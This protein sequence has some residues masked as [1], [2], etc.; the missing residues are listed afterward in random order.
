MRANRRPATADNPLLG[1]ERMASELIAGGLDAWG[2]AR[3]ALTEEIFLGV[4]GAPWLQAMVGLSSDDAT[5]KRGVERDLARE[6]AELALAAHLAQRVE[7]GGLVGAAVRALLYV[8]LPDSIA[9]ERGFA[10]LREIASELPAAKRLGLA[11]FKELVREQFLILRLDEERAIALPN[12]PPPRDNGPRPG[13]GHRRG[14]WGRR[15]GGRGRPGR[16]AAT[17]SSH[18]AR[19][20]SSSPRCRSS[21]RKTHAPARM[22]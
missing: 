19:S 9:D 11:R 21:C 17:R 1:Y 20:S 18:P 22:R 10:A 16:A 4:Y 8:R 2:K 7:A 3:D 15:P 5:R 12:L 14:R 13:P 6:A